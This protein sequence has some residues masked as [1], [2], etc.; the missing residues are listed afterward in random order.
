MT[1]KL[2]FILCALFIS[3][4][5]AQAQTWNIG[6]PNATDVTATLNATDSTLTISGTGNMQNW[7]A[8]SASST[9]VPW[10]AHQT[11]I[12]TV[13][14]EYGVANIGN[15]A[16]RHHTN[17]T[18]VAIPNS[19]TS[20]GNS[21]FMDC[22]ALTEITIPYGVTSIGMSAFWGCIGLTEITIPN[23]VTSI[24]M[25]AFTLC[26]GLITVNIGSGLTNLNSFFWTTY[27]YL[28]AINIDAENPEFSSENGVLFNKDKTT[29]IRFPT[30]KQGAYS[31]PNSVT[32]IEANA[33]SWSNGLTDIVIPNSVTSIGSWAFEN[34][35]AL[36]AFYVDA[37]NTAFSAENGVLFNKDRTTLIQFPI[38]K[39]VTAYT[40]PNSVTTIGW[41]A[42][43]RCT[44][45]TEITIPN[46]VTSI[47]QSAFR[48]SGITEIFIPNSVTSIGLGVFE[49]CTALTAINVD[50]DNPAFSSEN[51]VLFNKDKTTLIRF[52]IAKP[53]AAYTIPNSV[54]SIQFN[55]FSDSYYLLSVTI[56]YGVTSI[57]S[58]AFSGSG[59]TEIVIPNSVTSIG[60]SA[61]AGCTGLTEIVI[62]NSVTSIGVGAF[63]DCTNLTSLTIGKGV[64][65]IGTSAFENCSA[66]SD[67]YVYWINPP[68]IWYVFQNV[69]I[70]NVNLHIPH[71]TL[72]TYQN[73]PIWQD[74][75]LV[76]RDIEVKYTVSVTHNI[77]GK[78]LIDSVKIDSK[79]VIAGQNVTFT[80]TPN[81]G[82]EIESVFFNDIDV[83]AQLNDNNFVAEITQNSVL[84]VS[85]KEIPSS[86]NTINNDNVNLHT[87]SNGILIEAREEVQF[88]VFNVLGQMLYQ[89][90]VFGS[91]EI[92][93]P[94]GTYIVRVNNRNEKVIVK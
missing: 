33:F 28:T 35:T 32:S 19:V 88:A 77:G 15:N 8:F 86:I 42:F 37:D 61:F 43:S 54:T 76:E 49:E 40:I 27:Q 39:Q 78:V 20:I 63:R 31:I 29:L 56:H 55:A 57:G 21:A 87:T 80:I 46:S 75:I 51:G 38:A 69:D 23:S 50:A 72:F 17:L 52:P 94:A 14:I 92:A 73:A 45:L 2:L 12:R 1:K 68:R 5:T 65:N 9:S 53:V 62:P 89:S 22:T 3:T 58:S 6:H 10:N 41:S 7:M 84:N 48:G 66:L 90:A 30:G 47:G 18:I 82:F 70:Q 71:G 16:F 81:G 24:G 93:L 36:T 83:T 60:S 59:L 64:T 26:T 91:R 67:I 11:N 34:C 74:F 13:I 79:E 4:Q 85:F 25:M 44:G